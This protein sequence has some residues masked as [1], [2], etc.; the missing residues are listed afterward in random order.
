M[1]MDAFLRYINLPKMV[2]D[3]LLWM[4]LS[5]NITLNLTFLIL[6][7]IAIEGRMDNDFAWSKKMIYSLIIYLINIK[8][9]QCA[10][11]N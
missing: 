5:Q 4:D 8:R 7:T 1:D 2:N 11:V 9:K 6:I 3:E 10:S